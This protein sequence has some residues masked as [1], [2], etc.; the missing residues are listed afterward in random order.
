MENQIS[1]VNFRINRTTLK[2]FD[3]ACRL[4]G[5]TR[6]QVLTSLTRGYAAK[7]ATSIPEQLAESERV[8]TVLKN[9]LE[10]ASNRKRAMIPVDDEATFSGREI[11]NFS[12]F[13]TPGPIWGDT[14]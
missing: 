2:P 6:T 14:V 4:S 8:G 11:R 13:V 5:L 12:G 1:L 3:D 7:A 9:A 10:G